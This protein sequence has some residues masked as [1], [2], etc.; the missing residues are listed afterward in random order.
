LE[1]ENNIEVP[2][3][4]RTQKRLIV[5]AIEADSIFMEITHDVEVTGAT[6]ATKRLIIARV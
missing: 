2:P 4:A 5:V 6:C 3:S 1:I